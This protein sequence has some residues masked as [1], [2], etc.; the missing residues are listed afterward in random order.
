[1]EWEDLEMKLAAPRDEWDDPNA[2]CGPVCFKRP[3]GTWDYER[4]H[5]WMIYDYDRR[6]DD[7]EAPYEGRHNDPSWQEWRESRGIEP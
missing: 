3:N 2:E 6:T 5:R 7:N 4:F 1:M